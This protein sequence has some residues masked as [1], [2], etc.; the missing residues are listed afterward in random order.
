MSLPPPCQRDVTFRYR[1]G[2]GKFEG[3]CY[4]DDK[5]VCE[6]EMLAMIG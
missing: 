1:R 2:T 3:K 5:L 6:A 4:V